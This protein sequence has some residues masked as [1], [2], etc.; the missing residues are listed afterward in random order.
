VTDATGRVVTLANL[1]RRIVVVGPGP[2]MTLDALEMFPEACERVVGLEQRGPAG[3][4]FLEM[5]DSSFARK[6]VL[7][8]PGPEQIVALHPDLVISRGS[9]LDPLGTALGDVNI[10]I[11]YLGLETPDQ[12]KTSVTNL[13]VLFG[14]PAR[15]QQ[16]DRWFSGRLARVRAGVESPGVHRPHVLLLEYSEMGGTAAVRVPARQWM[17][18]LEVQTAGGEPVWLDAAAPASGW[19]V[20]NIEQIA[21]WDPDEIVLVVR[22]SLNA[23]QVLAKLRTDREWGALRAVKKGSLHAFPSDVYGWDSPDPRWIL[24]TEWLAKTLHPERFRDLDLTAEIHAYFGTLYRL[25]N[26]T[27]DSRLMPRIRLD[28]H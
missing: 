20:T 8:T 5:V 1:P 15:A 28:V 17:Q 19:T 23:A 16:V 25:G 13:G 12:F 11:V 21:R 14:D 22:Y 18:T 6:T 2:F 4:D 26:P 10:P 9:T 24:G 27:I 3:D 7:R